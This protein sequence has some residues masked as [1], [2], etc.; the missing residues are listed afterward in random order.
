[1]KALI[2]GITGQDGFYL[3]HELQSTRARIYG[4]VR[5]QDNPRVHDIPAFVNVLHGDVLDR[6]SLDSAL[7][8]C[9]PDVVFN[10]AGVTS[11]GFSWSQP[12][13]TADINA[14]GVI[15]LIEAM[16]S[17]VPKAVFIQAGSIAT[18]G[19]Y[20]ASK[21]FSRIAVADY[22]ARGMHATTLSM[23]GHHSPR[24]SE[25]FFSQKVVRAAVKIAR[26][27]MQQLQLGALSRT[28]DWGWADNF[29]QA[30]MAAASAQPGD[31]TLA[32]N[33]PHTLEEWVRIV[34]EKVNLD[35]HDYVKYETL[36]IQPYDVDSL[37]AAPTTRLIWEPR[38]DFSGLA[39]WMVDDSPLR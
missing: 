37:T 3:A 26:N 18:F 35:W 24:R 33:D 30:M 21:T 29:A 17:V 20:G 12:E 10:L 36:N 19:P 25:L 23:A 6:A 4:L 32:T 9:K 22:R 31:Y 38:V 34:F 16:R 11:P 15:R 5:G 27:E 2:T 1:M 14:L 7:E 8:E 28:Q 39:E 13:L